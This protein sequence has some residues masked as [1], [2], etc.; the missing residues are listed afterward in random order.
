VFAARRSLAIDPN[1]AEAY[2]SLGFIEL[3]YRWNWREAERQLREAIRRKPHSAR[4][5]DWLALTL[6]PRGR[7]SEARIAIEHAH[8]LDPASIDIA[9]DMILVRYLARDFAGAEGAARKLLAHSPGEADGARGLLATI[10][11]AT[12]RYAEAL[13][14]YARTTPLEMS[15]LIRAAMRYRAG[16]SEERTRVLAGLADPTVLSHPGNCDEIAHL[17]AMIGEDDLA[18]QWLERSY[19]R[20]EFALMFVGTDPVWDR[21]RG[22]EDFQDLIRRLHINS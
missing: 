19:Q 4:F 9:T 16:V 20:R 6:L 10:L 22:R 11:T 12:G 1:V 17:C 21:L 15:P 2:A 7:I 14:E 18:M 5:N 3:F 8:A 13:A